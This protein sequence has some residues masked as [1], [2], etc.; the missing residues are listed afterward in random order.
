MQ[1]AWPCMGS[2]WHLGVRVM[3]PITYH[4]SSWDH[5][6][7]GSSMSSQSQCK[8]QELLTNQMNQMCMSMILLCRL[9]S[10]LCCP[11]GHCTFTEDARRRSNSDI[12]PTT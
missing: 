4:P 5:V 12:W 6:T 1:T 2:W 10:E 8:Q 9:G 3:S 7:K 11:G